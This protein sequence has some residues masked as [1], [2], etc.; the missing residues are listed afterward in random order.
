MLHHVL[1]LHYDFIIMGEWVIMKELYV[2]EHL[3]R[4][5]RVR[6]LRDI[7]GLSRREFAKKFGI[8]SGTLQNW[9][10]KEGNGL[11]EKGAHRLV[12]VI[13]N[14]GILCHV[15]WL[16]YGTGRAPYL[17][18][19]TTINGSQ[20]KPPLKNSIPKEIDLFCS[21]HKEAICLQVKDDAMFPF[22]N[23]NDYVAGERCYNSDIDFCVGENCIV[24]LS[25]GEQ[26][27]RFLKK[28]LIPNLYDLA[29]LNSQTT[30]KK[31][32]YYNC[33]LIYAAPIIFW[34]KNT[35]L[36]VKMM[37]NDL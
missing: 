15:E 36:Q 24:L 8:A 6:C 12:C 17:I 7:T 20:K 10:D 31:P 30:D 11:T 22:Y 18:D 27:L 9:E 28:S 1:V 32:Y 34:R 4:S 23:I 19:P 26:L 35:T 14:A 16:M 25:S 37:I 2:K 5:M 21:E 13:N 33:K 29:S 3:A